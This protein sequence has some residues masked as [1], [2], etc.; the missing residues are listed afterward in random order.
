MGGPYNRGMRNSER[1]IRLLLLLPPLL[2]A[3]LLALDPRPLQQL[4]LHV[5]DQYQRWQPRAYTET[6]VRIV[7]IAADS[8]KRLRQWP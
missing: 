5:F 8:L 1:L 3:L 2:G 4:R 6:P 7:D